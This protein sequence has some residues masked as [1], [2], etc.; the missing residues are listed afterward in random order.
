MKATRKQPV[1]DNGLGRPWASS[2]SLPPR[3]AIRAYNTRTDRVY[4]VNSYSCYPMVKVL[5]QLVG[6]HMGEHVGKTVFNVG[7]I[8]IDSDELAEIQGHV[9]TQEEAAWTLPDNMLRDIERFLYGHA[10]S[11]DALIEQKPT[12]ALQ[13]ILAETDRL[14]RLGVPP[15]R[16]TVNEEIQLQSDLQHAGQK[17]IK[18]Q[19]KPKPKAAID[20]LGAQVSA[21]VDGDAAKLKKFAQ[22]NDCW[23]AKYDALPSAGLRRMN[24]VNRLRAKVRKGHQVVWK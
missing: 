8:R 2:P 21:F 23:D 3:Y 18:E 10:A 24:V 16:K 13:Q 15:R 4:A 9:L 20:D 14:D 6:V 1:A 22:A 5:Q 19:N 7:H 12:G 11:T 17:M